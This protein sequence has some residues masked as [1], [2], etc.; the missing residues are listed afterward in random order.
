VEGLMARGP[1]MRLW[2]IAREYAGHWMVAGVVLAATGAA[3]EHWFADVLHTARLPTEGLHLWGAGIDLRLILI[4]AGVL[5]IAGDIAW[6]RTRPTAEPALT[7]EAVEALPLPD[8]PSIAVLPFDNL[9]GDPEQEYFSDGVAEDII[10]ELS[11]NR[12]LFVIARNSSFTYR[13]RSVD[14]KQVGR[15]L[16]VRYV[17]EGSVRRQSERIRVAT[18]LIEAGTGAHVWAER[19]DR[20]QTDVFA[21]Q[22]EITQAVAVAIGPAVADAEMHRAMRRP[23]NSLG[24]WDL[25]QQAM[26]Q[27]ARNDVAA[28]DEARSLFLRAIELDPM[29][30]AA[31]SGLSRCE[32]RAFVHFQVMTLDAAAQA[33]SLHARKAIE[34]DPADADAYAS[35]AAKL[36]LQGDMDNALAIARQALSLNPNCAYARWAMGAVLVFTG[37]T[38]E[39]REALAEFERLSPRD[40]NI[41]AAHRQI[42]ISHYVD[43]NYTRCLEVVRRQLSARPDI[44]VTYRWLAAALG[45]LGR[46]EEARAALAKAFDPSSPEPAVY[47]RNR[48]PWM[49]PEDHEHLLEGLRKAGWQG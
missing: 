36:L 24:A 10:T 15:E 4:G 12:G 5:M 7:L 37:R 41:V 25:Y 20:D 11:R 8:K 33:A 28:N 6:R 32:T 27:M 31:H 45:Q 22:D 35:L 43:R 2:H 21:I 46:I 1:Y 13:G 30:A 47:G 38:A 9:S 3:P 39:G 48:V 34:L 40:S 23:P 42:A 29:F 19:Y 44:T 14:I 18:Q 49:R 17:L 16:G 26:W